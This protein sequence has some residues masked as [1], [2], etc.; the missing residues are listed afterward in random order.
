MF[1]F[2]VF[3]FRIPGRK[4]AIIF[5]GDAG[6]T[7]L[8]YIMVWFSLFL[9]QTTHT[10]SHVRFVAFLWIIALPLFDFFSAVIRRLLSK[11]TPL[12]SDRGH[13]HHVILR[14]GLHV[15]LSTPLLYIFAIVCGAVGV[16]GELN[17][18]S[19]SIL[20]LLFITICIVY[21][22]FVTVTNKV[23]LYIDKR[24]HLHE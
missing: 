4:Q 19:E 14:L 7:I 9:S 20:F 12:R 11:K 23:R 24:L 10:V 18:I 6:S 1:G 2:L 5:M 17:G 15:S 16:V 13:L 22:I 3:N 21:F 8:G